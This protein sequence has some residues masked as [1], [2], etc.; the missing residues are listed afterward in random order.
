LEI[1]RFSEGEVNDSPLIGIHFAEDKW[2]TAR[3]YSVCSELGHRAEFGLPSCT[4]AFDIA[5]KPLALGQLASKGL[6]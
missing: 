3:A 2:R 6:V 5:N 4:K 1:L